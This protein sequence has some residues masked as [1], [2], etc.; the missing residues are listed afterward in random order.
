MRRTEADLFDSQKSLSAINGTGMPMATQVNGNAS[1]CKSQRAM[2][3][4]VGSQIGLCARETDQRIHLVQQVA[5][6]T[7]TPSSVFLS[8]VKSARSVRP[9]QSLP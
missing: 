6:L 9:H 3:C 8:L 1:Q 5:R 4:D 7:Q 2:H